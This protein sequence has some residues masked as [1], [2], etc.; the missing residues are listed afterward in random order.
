M[1]MRSM[2]TESS[3]WANCKFSIMPCH[4]HGVEGSFE[5]FFCFFLSSS[6]STA[7]AKSIRLINESRFSSL[8]TS[9]QC[10]IRVQMWT[11]QRVVL[12]NSEEKKRVSLSLRRESFESVFFDWLQ[13]LD[14]ELVEGELQRH[15]FV[16]RRRNW[17]SQQ[18]LDVWGKET[19]HSMNSILIFFWKLRH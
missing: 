12:R 16:H 1:L 15:G 8:S 11:F 10:E 7:Q 4:C 19:T 18:F 14:W 2:M 6:F 5:L 3:W 9:L 13:T 17:F